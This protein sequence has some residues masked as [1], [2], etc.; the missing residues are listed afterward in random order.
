[1]D[2]SLSSH[3]HIPQSLFAGSLKPNVKWKTRMNS[4]WRSR[5]RT[6][7]L[8]AGTRVMPIWML[9]WETFAT[10]WRHY[11]VIECVVVC[12]DLF[13]VL[14]GTETNCPRLLNTKYCMTSFFFLCMP[15]KD[16]SAKER[17]LSVRNITW[18]F[19][20]VL[21]L[22]IWSLLNI[23]KL[24][25]LNPF[26]FQSA[27]IPKP[28]L[29]RVPGTYG[30]DIDCPILH[31]LRIRSMVGGM[32]PSMELPLFTRTGETSIDEASCGN[33]ALLMMC[34]CYQDLRCTNPR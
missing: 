11:P 31:I 10:T 17:G 29:Q 12:I 23:L 26:L 13:C 28:I 7:M 22:S 14:N 16:L 20:K 4:R 24:S 3:E 27:M 15:R 32:R 9:M 18:V 5:A 6:L 21:W 33:K 19:A 34:R 30:I 8:R 1:M 2:Y 25:F